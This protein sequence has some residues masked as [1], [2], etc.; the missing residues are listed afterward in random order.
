MSSVTV[1]KV[2]PLLQE[3]REIYADIIGVEEAL[4]RDYDRLLAGGWRLGKVLHAIKPQI[5]HSKW[6]FWLGANWPDLGELR[7]QRCM[8]FFAANEKLSNPSNLTDFNVDSIR[9]FLGGYIPAKIRPQLEGDQKLTPV[10]SFDAGTNKI[11]ALFHR[12]KEG[13]AQ[14]PPW[15]VVAPQAKLIFQGLRDIYGDDHLRELLS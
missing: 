4:R 2:R 13:H 14:A 11:A 12:V 10:V 9:K 1:D 3:A 5:G 8:A 6:L 15:E 7:A